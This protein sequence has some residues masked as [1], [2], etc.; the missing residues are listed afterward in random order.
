MKDKNIEVKNDINKI[1]NY[2]CDLF[3]D[4]S[5]LSDA[6]KDAV[7]DWSKRSFL[8][9]GLLRF[10][11]AQ[12]I[13]KDAKTYLESHPVDQLNVSGFQMEHIVP[14]SNYGLE[15]IKKLV[16]DERL[17]ESEKEAQIKKIV[18]EEM[19]VCFVTAKENEELN[20]VSKNKM[21]EEFSEEKQ[22]Y[23]VRYEKAFNLNEEKLMKDFFIKIESI[24]IKD[25]K[26]IIN[27]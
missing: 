25:N 11:Y 27:G 9:N 3:K 21:T 6:Q 2:Y 12:Y 20:K 8:G 13:S 10:A 14:K 7:K 15:K 26:I 16:K 19:R 4:Y 1:A 5:K 22:N 23:F 24:Q 18:A 17:S